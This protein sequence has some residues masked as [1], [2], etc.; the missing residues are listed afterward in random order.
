MKANSYIRPDLNVFELEAQNGFLKGS[1]TDVKI[2]VS[3][4]KV[5]DFQD[6]FEEIGGFKDISFD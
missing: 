4:V 2:R 3:Q 5:E 1:V 6:G